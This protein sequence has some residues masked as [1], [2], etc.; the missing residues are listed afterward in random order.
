MEIS[1]SGFFFFWE[2]LT[3]YILRS[4]KKNERGNRQHMLH[5]EKEVG[6]YSYWIC[7]KKSQV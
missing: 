4:K 1:F 6:E 5:K 2:E 3:I 7:E